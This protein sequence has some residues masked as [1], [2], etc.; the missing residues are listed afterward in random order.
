M[1]D[2]RC[3]ASEEKSPAQTWCHSSQLVHGTNLPSGMVTLL[4]DFCGRQNSWV[5]TLSYSFGTRKG[6]VHAM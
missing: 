5:Y 6:N 1:A 4:L 3:W 2:L